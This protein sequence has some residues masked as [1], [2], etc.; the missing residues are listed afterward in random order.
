[1]VQ[2][3]NNNVNII[4]SHKQKLRLAISIY[5]Y[6]LD[7]TT[8]VLYLEILRGMC[9]YTIAHAFCVKEHEVLLTFKH[10][11]YSF[12]YNHNEQLE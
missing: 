7:T 1:M 11:D 4:N 6:L 3:S 8:I 12:T 2:E 5:F 9:T 10:S